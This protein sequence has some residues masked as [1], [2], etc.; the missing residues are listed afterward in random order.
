MKR[1]SMKMDSG[2]MIAT[3]AACLRPFEE[4]GFDDGVADAEAEEEDWLPGFC[5]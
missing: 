5:L 3:G 4:D 1:E 2:S